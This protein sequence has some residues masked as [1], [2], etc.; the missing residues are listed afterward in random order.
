MERNL[1]RR[2]LKA[3]GEK[4]KMPWLSWHVFRHS[5]SAYDEQIGLALSDRQAQMGHSDVGMTLHYIHSDLERRRAAIENI[6]TR[7]VGAGAA[8]E[9]EAD[10][11][12]K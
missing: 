3:A 11:D 1:T 12:T 2:V 7:L 4:L 10:C 9:K 5:H 8:S 6:A